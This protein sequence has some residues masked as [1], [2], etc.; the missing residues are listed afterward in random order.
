MLA[1]RKT[2]DPAL[3]RW[4]DVQTDNVPDETDLLKER[5]GQMNNHFGRGDITDIRVNW[6]GKNGNGIVQRRVPIDQHSGFA[7]KRRFRVVNGVVFFLGHQST[8][9]RP[10]RI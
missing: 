9:S 6:D 8:L 3:R 7:E 1:F 4:Y 2:M 5:L 10:F